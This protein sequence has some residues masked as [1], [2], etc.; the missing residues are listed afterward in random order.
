LRGVLNSGF[1]RS[2]QVIRVVERNGEYAPVVFATFCP[3]ASAAIGELPATRGDRA[4]P[5][6]LERKAASEMVKMRATGNH[7]ALSDLAR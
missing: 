5:I 3:V 6:R 4:V 7:V 2:G 1:E